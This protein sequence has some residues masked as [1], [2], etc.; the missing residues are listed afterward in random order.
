MKCP[1][2]GIYYDEETEKYCPICGARKPLIREAEKKRGAHDALDKLGRSARG[3]EG[4]GAG[5]AAR[6]AER[7]VS[8]V[9]NMPA[10]KPVIPYAEVGEKPEREGRQ[11]RQRARED[12][13]VRFDPMQKKMERRGNKNP[14][15]FIV[16]IIII[17]FLSLLTNLFST[18]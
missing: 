9:Y 17:I 4:D 11:R 10:K 2:C 3:A 18:T 15:L 1:E 14:S 5:A 13:Q 7:P 12:A 6:P 16:V 8:A